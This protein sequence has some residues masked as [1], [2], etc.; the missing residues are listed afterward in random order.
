MPCPWVASS[1]EPSERSRIPIAFAASCGRCFLSARVMWRPRSI[2]SSR[3]MPSAASRRNA[4]RGNFGW[5]AVTSSAMRASTRASK[6]SLSRYVTRE[7]RSAR[8]EAQAHAQDAA[9]GGE[10]AFDR[11]ATEDREQAARRG[12]LAE[13]VVHALGGDAEAREFVKIRGV[14][15]VRRRAPAGPGLDA[16]GDALC[17]H[18]QDDALVRARERLAAARLLDRRAEHGSG[19]GR[20]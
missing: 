10:V 2:N 15:P 7:V 18:A 17:V 1:G 19:G 20:A 11:A 12:E 9:V 16:R 13:H 8:G 6:K 5:T 4:R 14:G 3:F